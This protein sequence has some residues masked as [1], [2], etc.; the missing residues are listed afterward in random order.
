MEPRRDDV[1]RLAG[2]A[3]A[4]AVLA[5][6]ELLA[7][8]LWFSVSAVVPQL[9]AEWRLGGREA[10]WLAMAV[11]IGFV[12]GALAS[13][14]LNLADR[15]PLRGLFASCALAGA[16][17]NAA[18]PLL[19]P[20]LPGVLALRFLTGAALAGV[21]PPGMKLV[22]TW[23]REDRGFGIG[24]LVGA[25]TLG[26][27]T[28]HL[29][30]ALP[31]AGAAGMPP[32]RPVL[33]AT[34]ALAAAAALL[35]LVWGRPG[36]YLAGSAPFDWRFAFR[37]FAHRP[38]RLANFGYLGHMWELY[39][40]WAWAPLLL[41]ASY[42]AAGAGAGGAR[43]AGF[44]V[45]AAGAAGS[46][47]AGVL[48]DRVGRT[49]VASWSLAVSGS[50]ALVAGLCFERPALLTALCLVWGFAVVADSAQ[51]SAAV[52]EL[53]DPRY[54]GTALTLQTCLGFLLTLA[55]I[56]LVPELVERAGWRWAFA[57][58]ALGPAFGLWSMLRLRRLPEAARMAGGR[59]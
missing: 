51:F 18:V 11:Q 55:T 54:V 45:I 42:R 27:A 50:C 46:V 44:G 9:T 12:A 1:T 34:S 8:G 58:L 2:K 4:L 48:A 26:K 14:L 29:L 38:T 31:F 28:P 56:G 52:S 25:L 17:L 36:P 23:C 22:A 19:E 3:R 16:A 43:L 15:V 35:A 49:A 41:L 57:V 5:V 33:L 10:A 24:L 32:W 30:N 53:S 40:M 47:L 59:R 7:M 21:Y 20:G 13:A 6:A 37:A 39:A